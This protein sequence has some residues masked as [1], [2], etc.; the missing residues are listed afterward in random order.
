MDPVLGFTLLLA[1]IAGFGLLMWRRGKRVTGGQGRP[2]AAGTPALS[3]ACISGPLAGR[4]FNFTTTWLRLGRERDNEIVIDSPLVSRHHAL[5][6]VTPAGVALR[7]LES[8]NGTWVNGRR[9]LEQSLDENS[10][11]QIGPCVF[12]L[13]GLG[14]TAPPIQPPQPPISHPLPSISLSM[15]RSVEIGSYDQLDLVGEGGAAYVYKMRHRRTGELAALKILKESA[16]P[17]F[18]QRFAEEGQI[19]LKL[20]HPHIVEVYGTGEA[21]GIHYILMEYLAGQSLRDRFGRPIDLNELI[22]IVAQIGSALDYAHSQGVFHRDIKP[23]NILFT[24]QGVA[25]LGDFGIARLT[26]VRRYTSEGM[27][28]GTPEYMS[29]EQAK[30]MEL[31]GRSDQYSLAIVMYEML[32]GRP[33][34]TAANPLAVVE[35]HLSEEPVPVRRLN[36]RVPEQVERTIMRSLNK[37]RNRRYTTMADMAG[38][39]G[40]RAPT[41]AV[42]A[43]PPPSVRARLVHTDSGRVWMLDR[44]MELGREMVDHPLVSRRHARI[45]PNGRTYVIEDLGSV[46]GTYVEGRRITAPT[47]LSPGARIHLGPAVAFQFLVEEK[48]RD[49][50]LN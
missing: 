10:S 30:G 35:K 18:K 29:F 16:D 6:N 24:D 36:P 2:P 33:P 19:G 25:K 17:Y 3:I 28:I 44:P 43:A 5:V 23:E 22:A 21:N 11:F 42:A 4:Q 38:A 49:G 13:V 40:Y 1:V 41:G 37:D 50:R 45:Q 46:N 15:A 8:T 32:A 7:D 31:D 34:F 12:A 9:I 14:R 27:I 20:S 47:V 48:P 39:L 26:G